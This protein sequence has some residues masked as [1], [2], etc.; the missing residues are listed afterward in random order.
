ME[1]QKKYTYWLKAIEGSDEVQAR[2][3]AAAMALEIG[4]GGI[5]E[6]QKLTGMSHSTI[7]KGIHELQS[8]KKLEVPDR[9]RIKGGGR[10]KVEIN[11]ETLIPD[12]EKIMD[13]KTA[14]D[15]MSMLKWTNKSTYTI[16]E[17]LKRLGHK[18]GP[19]T[20]GRI[21][22][23]KDYSLQANA[24]TYEGESVP[25][26]DAQFRFINEQAK[27]FSKEFNPIISVD[28]KKK[29]KVGNFKNSGRVWQKS[30]SS[31]EVNVYDFLSLGIG[32]SIPYGVYDVQKNEGFVNVGIS[33]DT[34]EFAVQS[35]RQW[36]TL[37]GKYEYPNA[38]G[39]MICADGGGSNGSRVL[40]WKY[41]LQ[42]F[43]DEIKIPL[44]ICHY[45]PG[46][47]KWN[48]IEHRLFSFISLNWKGKPL[49][50]YETV[51]ELI[52]S[53]KTDMG[54]KV[55]ACLDKREY[56]LARKFTDEEM[57]KLNIIP[58]SLHPKWNYTIMSSNS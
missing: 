51:I 29:E 21:L 42:E 8:S 18:V 34:S 5:S 9:L 35:I 23:E 45:P 15:P 16:A 30:G 7:E 2:R 17:E 33:H 44:S 43:S 19:N 24:K 27:K 4:W 48:K 12:I 37:L 58:D 52:G 26:R 53:T 39:I 10:K 6:V 31:K 11:D 54:L 38:T 28:T 25:E 1:I 13:E 46:T 20:V 47:S 57:K 56:E 36:W 41:F 40:G 55:K 32:I 14:G 22:K 50:N 3:Y 49:I